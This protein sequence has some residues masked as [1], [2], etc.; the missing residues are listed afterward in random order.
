MHALSKRKSLLQA[1]IQPDSP[2]VS[3]ITPTMNRERFLIYQYKC[4]QSQTYSNFEWL[5]LDDSAQ[6]SA[7][8]ARLED[9]RIHYF[10]SPQKVNVGTKRNQLIAKAKGSIIMHIDDDDYYSPGYI[11]FMLDQLQQGHDLVKL[12]GFYLYSVTLQKFGY[13]NLLKKTGPYQMWSAESAV[14]DQLTSLNN[15]GFAHNHLGYGFSYAYKKSLQK[16]I[17][18]ADMDFYEEGQFIVDVSQKYKIKL[19]QDIHGLCLHILHG[20]NLSRCFPQYE[21]PS[22]MLKQIFP[23]S[24]LSEIGIGDLPDAGSPSSELSE[25]YMNHDLLG[26]KHGKHGMLLFNKKDFIGASVNLYGEWCEGEI[27]LLGPYIKGNEVILDVGANIGTH[28]VALAKK[29]PQGMLLAFEPQRLMY[30]ML[31][32][33]LA[34][35]GIQNVYAFQAGVGD[36]PG[37][38]NIPVI[39]HHENSNR[40][41]LSI[42]GHA[43]GEST[44]ILTIDQLQLPHCHL[45]KID[46]EGM[47]CKVL[48]GAESTIE[49][50]KPIIFV[51]NNTLDRSALLIQHLYGLD[52]VCWWHIQPYYNPHNY[53]GS[54][55]NIYSQY[56][57][58]ANMLCFHKSVNIVPQHLIIV[59]SIQDNWQKAL[60]RS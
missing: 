4:L 58:E 45:V 25:G 42:E 47:E 6:A 16:D 53:Y 50:F 44:P 36:K 20:G 41:A 28:T 43:D 15:S 35:N 49:K 27:A 51:E 24:N 60:A 9:S 59:E 32:A 33:N 10:H 31:C 3:L 38:V 18:F 29:A 5:I 34:L 48:K 26:L 56:Q 13:W 19:L 8:F 37:L 22:F 55:E 21:L 30:Q 12:S 46:V 23:E 2:L 39:H 14:H 40:G 52:Y 57:P 54:G 17:P 1:N 7:F 11:Q